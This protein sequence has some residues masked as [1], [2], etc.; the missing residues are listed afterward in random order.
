M[1]VSPLT[2]STSHG[3]ISATCSLHRRPNPRHGA[4]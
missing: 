3:T 1:K 2:I 4:D